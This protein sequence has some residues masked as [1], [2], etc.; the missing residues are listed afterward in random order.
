MTK[1][2]KREY[3]EQDIED[4]YDN[5]VEDDFVEVKKKKKIVAVVIDDSDE[6]D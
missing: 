2:S 4:E 6:D 5:G 3:K 1:G